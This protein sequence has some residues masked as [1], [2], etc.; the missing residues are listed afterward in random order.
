L[1][2]TRLSELGSNFYAPTVLTDV[3]HD[4]RI[5]TEETFGPVLPIMSFDI[6]DEAV[7]LANDSVYGLAA[8]VWT[9]DRRRGELLAHRLRAGTVMINDSDFCVRH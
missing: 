8:S 4:M 3:T 2:G 5:M 7:R 1:R 6:E 9:G